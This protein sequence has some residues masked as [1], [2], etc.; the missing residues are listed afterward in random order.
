GTM[1]LSSHP[2]AWRALLPLPLSISMPQPPR[3]IVATPADGD[4]LLAGLQ[5]GHL[6]AGDELTGLARRETPGAEL[7]RRRGTRRQRSAQGVFLRAVL[8]PGGDEAGQQHIARADRG[9]RVH[10]R[11]ERPVAVRLALRAEQ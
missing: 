6:D 8:E 2:F 10:A 11:R 7:E 4:S 3:A 9:N 5:L 1:C